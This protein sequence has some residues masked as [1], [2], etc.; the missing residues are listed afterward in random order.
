MDFSYRQILGEM[1]AEIDAALP[2][3]CS[4]LAAGRI[5]RLC[6]RRDYCCHELAGH[7]AELSDDGARAVWPYRF[8]GGLRCRVQGS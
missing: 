8:G 2:V 1:T 7:T 3:V 4:G 5:C 6:R